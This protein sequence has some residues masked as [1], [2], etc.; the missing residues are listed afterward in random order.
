MA[1]LVRRVGR[2]WNAWRQLSWPER[3]VLVRSWV[4]LLPVAGGLRLLGFRRMQ[5]L[6]ARGMPREVASDR[7][8]ADRTNAVLAECRNNAA[9]VNIAATHGLYR[10]TC[11]PR[12][13]TLWWLLGSQGI[14]TDLCLGVRRET[15]LFEA[16]AWVEYQGSVLNDTEDVTQRFATL[17]VPAT[18]ASWVR[19]P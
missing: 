12:S 15:G 9:L 10:A 16:H 19:S 5:R 7:W 3:R 13:L 2:Y 14:A 1:S 4:L 11:L 17:D 8:G 6:L 18:G